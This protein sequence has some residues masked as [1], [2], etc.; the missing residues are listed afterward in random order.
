VAGSGDYVLAL[1]DN[2][3]TLHDL[4]QHH[5]VITPDAV[6]H[7]TV[8]K[9]HSRLEIRQCGATD[10]PV[11]LTWLDP[12]TPGRVRAALPRWR[13]NAAPARRSRAR[14]GTT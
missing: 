5:F 3:P 14:P 13:A 2:Q 12:A 8:D 7:R 11:V 4:V 10:D 6:G 9:D 1:K